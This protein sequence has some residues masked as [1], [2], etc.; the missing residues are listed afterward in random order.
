MG[1]TAPST[2]TTKARFKVEAIGQPFF[3]I[4]HANLTT[5][6]TTAMTVYRPVLGGVQRS[7]TPTSAGVISLPISCAKVKATL[8]APATC[9][10]TLKIMATLRGQYRT[11]GV[12]QFSLPN[13]QS[14]QVQVQLYSGA[15]R[16]LANSGL[17]STVSA[18]VG[19]RTKSRGLFLGRIR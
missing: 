4:S 3:D 5:T 7:V 1:R 9:E 2:I 8:P 19:N 11:V 12:S 17:S 18:T 16:A 10:G 14:G 6:S 15:V 13:G